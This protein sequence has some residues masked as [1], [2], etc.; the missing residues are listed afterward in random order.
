MTD[1]KCWKE[2]MEDF[3]CE[4]NDINCWKEF[5]PTLPC[6]ADHYECWK[7]L[8]IHKF[9]ESADKFSSKAEESK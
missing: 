7:T 2:K 4:T 3:P 1:F 5:I 8:T 9:S 6:V